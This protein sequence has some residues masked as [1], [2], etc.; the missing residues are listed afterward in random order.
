MPIGYSKSTGENPFKGKKRPVFSDEHRLKISLSSKG[1]I[2]WNKGKKGL[3]TAS[4]ETREKMSKAHSNEKHH[5][6]KGDKA[7]YGSKHSWIRRK[8]GPAKYGQCLKC[9]SKEKLQWANVDHKYKRRLEDWM[10]LCAVCHYK[11]DEEIL[12]IIHGYNRKQKK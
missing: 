11:Y 12:N 1:R 8:K 6:W 4:K 5:G 7:T 3:Q 9:E 2:P 10:I